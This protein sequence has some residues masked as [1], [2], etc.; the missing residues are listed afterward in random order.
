M[1]DEADGAD[2]Y[3]VCHDGITLD[4]CYTNNSTNFR[5]A[6]AMNGLK[7][8]TY[9]LEI[10]AVYADNTRKLLGSVDYKYDENTADSDSNT[11][12]YSDNP[13]IQP[14]FHVEL[15]LRLYESCRQG[16]TRRPLRGHCG[17]TPM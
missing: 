2:H 12:I 10:Y 6:M 11:F 9:T 16:T 13:D 8:G 1:W 5:T 17:R 7:Y 3:E 4:Y 15:H 14:I